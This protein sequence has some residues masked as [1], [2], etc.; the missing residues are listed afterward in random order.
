MEEIKNEIMDKVN[1]YIPHLAI[2]KPEKAS[3][4]L[5]VVFYV[6]AKT[7]SGFCLNSILLNGGIIHQDL[8][9]IVSR[10]RKHKYASSADIRK[11]YRKILNCPN[12]R[13]LQ[14]I[15]WNTSA[16]ASVKVHKLSTVTYGT[17]SAPFFSYQDLKGLNR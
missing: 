6:S 17:V 13:D 16:D 15:V 12:Q 11:M 14:S 9:S 8:F 5:R 2:F 10:F 4:P 7:T 1:Y 3:T